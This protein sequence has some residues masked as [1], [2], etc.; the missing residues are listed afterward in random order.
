MEC[1]NCENIVPDNYTYCPYCGQ[2]TNVSR[3]NFR[4]SVKD[5]WVAFSNTD[6]GV[7]LLIKELIYRPGAVA[8]AYVAGRR[9]T[10]VNPFSYLAIMVAI[11]LYFIIRFENVGLDYSQMDA[12]DVELFMI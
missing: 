3:L 7:L 9:R 5:I 4:Q 6:K 1:K 2:K 12:S 10:Y 11:A 8:R